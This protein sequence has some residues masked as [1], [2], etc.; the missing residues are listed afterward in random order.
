MK[1]NVLLKDDTSM[2]M[3]SRWGNWWLFEVDT[4]KVDLNTFIEDAIYGSPT[5]G[6]DYFE[7]GYVEVIVSYD[8]YEPLGDLQAVMNGE[9]MGLDEF[10]WELEDE[11]GDVSVE[12]LVT[13]LGYDIDEVFYDS[14][15]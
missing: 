5:Y 11:M 6:E 12:D 9:G 8:D 15:F 13:A 3:S 2:S 4:D 14:D 7:P 1:K 10:Y